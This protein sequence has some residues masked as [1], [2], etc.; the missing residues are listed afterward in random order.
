MREQPNSQSSGL[1]DGNEMDS[2]QETAVRG[3]K[4]DISGIQQHNILLQV[5]S[6][7]ENGNAPNP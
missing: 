4:K 1:L 3:W 2:R 5:Y 6:S 7:A